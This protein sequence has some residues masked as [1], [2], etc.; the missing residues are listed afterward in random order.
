[1]ATSNPLN[2]DLES[3]H[4]PTNNEQ[5]IFSLLTTYLPETS[6]IS[7]DQAAD[8]IN[9]RLPDHRPGCKEEKESTADFLFEFWE[10]MFRIA[11]QLDYRHE[12]MQRLI[13]LIKA[14]RNL[15][16]T[17]VIQDGGKYDGRPVWRNGLYFGPMLHERWNRM[18]FF[19]TYNP[20]HLYKQCQ[21]TVL[22]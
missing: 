2:L 21:Y 15:P 9:A 18:L 20:P 13:L 17:I 22:N 1:M 14:L 3:P 10:L 4:E 12:P 19:P 7:P 6:T 8:Q 5:A 16:E 11:P